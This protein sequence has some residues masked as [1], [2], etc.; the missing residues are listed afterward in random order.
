MIS[1]LLTLTLLSA[2]A[3]AAPATTPPLVSSGGQ[4]WGV[5]GARTAGQGGNLI[6]GGLGWPGIHVSYLRGI[7]PSLDLGIR[8]GLN[9]AYE[10]A[11]QNPLTGFKGQFLLHYKLYDASQVSVA[12]IFEPGPLF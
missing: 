7:T 6:E 10:G 8:V 4:N 12:F 5:V 1:T 9:Y 2:T 3:T 11:V